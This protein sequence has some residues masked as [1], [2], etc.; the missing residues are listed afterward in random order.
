MDMKSSYMIIIQSNNMKQKEN[1]FKSFDEFFKYYFP[2]AHKEKK[3]KQLTA[4]QRAAKDTKKIINE[5]LKG[6]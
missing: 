4:E 5:I 6:L 3:E 1:T 2:K